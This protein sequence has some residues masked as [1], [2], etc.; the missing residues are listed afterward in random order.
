MDW[1]VGVIAFVMLGVIVY[2]ASG[3]AADERN[4][5][6]TKQNYDNANDIDNV[7]ISFNITVR[8]RWVPSLIGMFRAMQS[9][10]NIGSS[11]MIGFYSDGDGDF[12]PKFEIEGTPLWD[13]EN[14][15]YSEWGEL[16][17]DSLDKIYSD[18]KPTVDVWFDAG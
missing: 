6:D 10:G 8:K 18:S 4:N 14:Q 17:A 1:I 16:A 13:K 12:R 15:K 11:R 5:I 2:G 7:T 9:F 3:M